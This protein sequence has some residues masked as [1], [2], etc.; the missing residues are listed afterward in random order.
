[1]TD[2][3]TIGARLK[4][5]VRGEVYWDAVARGIHATD[6]SF[7]QLMPSAV[8]CPRD[9]AD[10]V[11]T[12][13]VCRELGVSV[14]GRGTGTSLS[15]QTIGTGVI[16]DLSRHMDQ[17]LRVDAEA[18]TARVQAGAVQG[19]INARLKALGLHFAPDPATAD[20]AS[21]GGMIGNNS[22]GMRS[23]IYG[24]T[25]DHLVALRVAL[26]DGRVVELR[27]VDPAAP[28]APLA[29]L[30]GELGKIAAEYRDDIAKAYPAVKRSVSGY[31]LRCLLEPQWDLQ[32]L[33]AG[34]EGT[35]AVVLEAE[36]A[37]STLPRNPLMVLLRYPDVVSSLRNVEELVAVCHPSAIEQLDG[38]ILEEAMHNPST[39]PHVGPLGGCTLPLLIVEITGDHAAEVRDRAL[40]LVNSPLGRSAS[41]VLLESLADQS[42]IWEIRRLG[43]GLSTNVPGPLKPLSFVEDSGIP[44]KH[45]ADFAQDVFDICKRHDTPCT[46][47]GHASVGVLHLKPA[48]D[49]HKP[50][51]AAL[52]ET[53]TREVMER[54]RVYGGSLSGEHGDGMVRGWLLREFFSPRM[55]EAFT[56]VKALFDPRGMLNPGKIINPPGMQEHLRYGRPYALPQ[57]PTQ[58]RYREHGSFALAVEQCNG[59]GACRKI[60]SGV[61]CPSYMALRDERHSTRG[62][63]NALRLAMTGQLGPE[64]M[65]SD[66]LHEVLSLCLSC[67]ACRSEC[68]NGVDVARLKAEALQYR[69]DR[70]GVPL[71]VRLAGLLP[72]ISRMTPGLLRP[73]VNFL[74]SSRLTAPLLADVAGTDAR[75]RMPLL[76]RRR[77][78]AQW[79]PAAA[80]SRPKVALFADTWSDGYEPPVALAARRLLEG[81]G[82]DVELAD[83]GCCQR[84]RIS[85]GLLREAATAGLHTLRKLDAWCVRGIDVL[86]LEPSCHSALV[87]DLP[88]LMDETELT[89]RVR[90]HVR[91][92]ESFLAD[93]L[94]D[95]VRFTT[96]WPRIFVHGHC[97]QK[98]G[99][100]V[101]PVL[102]VLK[103]T[104]ADVT[105]IDA[106]CCGMAG[107]F[108][109]EH[110]DVSKAV[111]EDRL[112]PA[113]RSMPPGS[114][115]VASGF[116]C[117]HQVA[118]FTGAEAVHL[119]M[120]VEV[121]P[122]QG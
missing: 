44:L 108:G 60:G 4:H 82:Y 121:A 46:V 43:L 115:L 1:M 65:E 35:L 34:A 75:R 99:E 31:D 96:R 55:I 2:P 41:A 95:G 103:S 3:Q 23:P 94:D 88:D 86:V 29:G 85:K 105:M 24:M 30:C 106:G 52:M 9:E 73:V 38:H 21:V 7:Y 64:A 40:R 98:A 116:S 109:Y 59:V 122:A 50:E 87:E 56:R 61:M 93:R 107:A 102:R 10:V 6:A 51:H 17:V 81:C 119:A 77:L 36:L 76:A 42:H 68:P 71:A 5:L 47:Y 25:A 117:R 69:Y 13:Q 32:R 33:I 72:T 19:R 92:F 26:A 58:Y 22:A 67:K 80:S 54:V 101:D 15:G 112:F 104:G 90:K 120:A 113:I 11:A 110:Y 66:E 89:A 100:G 97:H 78:S 39:M 118:D 57:L 14:V 84:P 114:A 18:R 111:G 20:R 48:L 49:L 53:I 63:A 37:L 70:R 83:A 74:Q 16:L 8:V 62:R 91:T 27:R 45:V 79:T 28:P 12:L